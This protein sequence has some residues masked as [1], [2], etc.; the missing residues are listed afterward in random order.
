MLTDPCPLSP[1]QVRAL[2]EC[3]VVIEKRETRY[4]VQWYYRLY[5]ETQLGIA[6]SG[7]SSGNASG[8]SSVEQTH[9]S[10]LA[11]GEMLRHTGEFMLS[12][13]KEVAETVLRLHESK[14]SFFLS[15][16]RVGDVTDGVFYL[17]LQER[18]VRRSV[19]ELIPRLAAFSPARFAESYLSASAATLLATIRSPG[20]RDAGFMAVGDLAAALASDD[21]DKDGADVD[22]S[23]G[24]SNEGTTHRAARL[25][26]SRDGSAGYLSG[27]FF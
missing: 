6:G 11:F 26:G 13:Y 14:V 9:G 5:E 7:K 15:Y 1:H 8:A 19:T 23:D 4:R 22:Q 10:L 21:A 12:R 27:K 18:I 25:L 17:P 24:V 2:R 20:E 3:L 16:F